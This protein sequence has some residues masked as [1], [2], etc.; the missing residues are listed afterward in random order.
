MAT[1]SLAVSE[2]G[3]PTSRIFRRSRRWLNCCSVM[4]SR[5]RLGTFQF[6]SARLPPVLKTL[7][8]G[9]RIQILVYSAT[10]FVPGT[11]M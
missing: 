5:P 3:K 9:G 4:P 1:V 10:S 2:P 11:I 8:A 7:N 6:G